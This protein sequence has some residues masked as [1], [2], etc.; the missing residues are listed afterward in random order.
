MNN[1]PP[2]LDDL[3]DQDADD[4]EL[5]ERSGRRRPKPG[6]GDIVRRALENMQ[7]TGNV[8]REALQY[9]LHQGDRGK[10][11]VVRIVAKEVGEFLRHVDISQE[12]IKVLTSVQVDF[13]A[14]VKFK[15][16]DQGVRPEVVSD[17][18]LAVDKEPLD[19]SSPPTRE[20]APHE[21]E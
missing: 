5:D 10:R 8:S 1:R 9:V 21:G 12:V 11:E 19:P 3:F 17:T 16:T 4:E 2:E 6:V 13:S 15:P 14:S 7:S 20:S 18:K